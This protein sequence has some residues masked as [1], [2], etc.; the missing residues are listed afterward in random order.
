MAQVDGYTIPG[1]PL[2]MAVLAARLEALFAAA[3][4]LNRGSSAPDSPFDGMV[5][6]DTSVSNVE[7][8]K[9]YKGGWFSLFALNTS[10]GA[11]TFYRN[12][13]TATVLASAW[14][15]TL[16]DDPD[17]DTAL[18]TLGVSAFAKTI[19]DDANASTVLSTLGVTAF[20]KTLLD[21]ADAATARETLGVTF[22]ALVPDGSITGAKLAV[23]AAGTTD[24]LISGYSSYPTIAATTTYITAFEY[25]VKR[26]GVMRLSYE[27]SG[28]TTSTN[29]YKSGVNDTYGTERNPGTG[30]VTYTDDL[31][32]VAGDKIRIQMK[33]SNAAMQ[34]ISIK[35]IDPLVGKVLIG[36]AP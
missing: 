26:N 1:S 36:T 35:C 18:T 9:Y 10:T 6:A 28:N 21:D 15:L 3:G 25:E 8:W 29:R 33:G 30:T 14:A 20:A 19:L 23:V 34:N 32:V 2:S 17:A 13:S 22:A 16:L 11:M 7:T 24:V 31:T 12:A 4:S 27:A 5:W